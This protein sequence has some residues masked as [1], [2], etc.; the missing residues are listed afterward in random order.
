MSGTHRG[1]RRVLERGD[2]VGREHDRAGIVDVEAV[3]AQH[4]R[5]GDMGYHLVQ[6]EHERG[7]DPPWGAE[8]YVGGIHRSHVTPR[9]RT[10]LSAR[11]RWRR[12]EDRTLLAAYVVPALSAGCGGWP[13]RTQGYGVGMGE[14]VRQRIQRGKGEKSKCGP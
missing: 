10:S 3:A 14:I 8:R 1:G 13:T 6:R 5:S 12:R 11:N 4:G 9:H 7:A 2:L